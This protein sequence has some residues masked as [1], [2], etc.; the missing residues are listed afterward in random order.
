MSG[1]N[2]LVCL[3]TLLVIAGSSGQALTD[4][5]VS[6]TEADINA[7]LVGKGAEAVLYPGTL[8]TLSNPVL[9]TAPNQRIYTH[10]LQTGASRAVLRICGGPLTNHIH[11]N[12]QSG[13]TL[14]S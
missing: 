9:F 12:N 3:P 10:G 11:A 13:L 14:P 4:C 8:F 6:G 1:A 2:S 5:I 7:A